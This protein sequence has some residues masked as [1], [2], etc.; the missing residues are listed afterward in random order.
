MIR[1]ILFDK[2]NN[3]EVWLYE[4]SNDKLKVGITDFGGA[5]QYLK[6]STPSGEKEVCLGFN[7]IK[8]Y[9]ASGT[10]CGATIGRVANRI[11]GAKFS[12]NGKEHNL[13]VN[14][15]NN[16]LHG[17]KDGFDK[18]FF[19]AEMRGDFL[20][21]SLESADG[22]MGFPGNLKF[23]A[24]FS[25]NGGALEIKYIAQ[26]DKDTI[27]IPTCHAYFNLGSGKIYDTSLKIYS[28][29]YTPI[30]SGLIPTGE[31]ANVIGT[32]F[33]FTVFKPIGRDI[34]AENE[35][36][37]LA[38]GYDHNFIL[39]G[40]HAA[41]AMSGKNGIIMDVY[42]DM[43]AIQFYSGNMIK[44]NGSGGELTPR[45]GF[46][47]EPQFCPNSVNIAAFESPVLEAGETKVHY[48]HYVFS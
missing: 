15:G 47:L 33:D 28:D 16:T 32:P 22:D 2:Y 7:S 13:S 39:K 40:R 34:N 6:V 25:L 24:E 31:V 12:L 36:L 29:K 38:G 46:C 14:D 48:I 11:G 26:S 37:K 8:E 41:T 44:G 4:L 27:W 18:L 1:K 43:P 42:T 30:D 3:R 5:I 20:T 23:K 21:L 19:D 45:D 17:G 10:Y 9:L 35:Q